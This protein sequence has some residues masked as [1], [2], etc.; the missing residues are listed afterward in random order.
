MTFALLLS[1]FYSV[2]KEPS[3][4]SGAFRRSAS[5]LVFSSFFSLSCEEAGYMPLSFFRQAFVFRFCHFFS[6]HRLAPLFAG[7]HYNGLM[8]EAAPEMTSQGHPHRQFDWIVG[9]LLWTELNS[10]SILNANLGRESSDSSRKAASTTH[11]PR[12]RTNCPHFM[13]KRKAPY[14]RI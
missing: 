9:F 14:R 6:E 10:S 8:S 4:L 5:C 1:V 12:D 2:F 11:A 13:R 7:L 3:L